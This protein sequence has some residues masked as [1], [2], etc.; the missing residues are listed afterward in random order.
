MCRDM[1]GVKFE[2]PIQSK[3]DWLKF[4]ALRPPTQ[5]FELVLSV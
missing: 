3:P 4:Q 1:G 2:W 5:K